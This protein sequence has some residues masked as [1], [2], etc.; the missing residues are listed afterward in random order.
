MRVV[1]QVAVPDSGRDHGVTDKVT[2]GLVW[3]K[4][5]FRD[6]MVILNAVQLGREI[7]KQRLLQWCAIMRR[8]ERF[9]GHV[10]AL[11]DSEGGGL[12]RFRLASAAT[13]NFY[14]QHAIPVLK[15]WALLAD[16]QARQRTVDIAKA[17]A[18]KWWQWVDD[19]VR[20]GAGAL[21]SYCKRDE[22]VRC[23]PAPLL[24]PGGFT[25]GIQALLD[26]D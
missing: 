11:V 12:W 21:H 26:N 15:E 4:R 5:G 3:I 7:S 22:R 18:R 10:Q 25:L 16:G 14:S 20:S 8:S 19:Q 1:R 23:A 24:V 17:A 2:L 13:L 6:L 9:S